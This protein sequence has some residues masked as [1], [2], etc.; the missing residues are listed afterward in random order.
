MQSMLQL[1]THVEFVSS[2]SGAMNNIEENIESLLLV[3]AFEL[4]RLVDGHLV[5]LV[6]MQQE[7]R[8]IARI[9]V[10]DGTGQPYQFRSVLRP[11]A[12]K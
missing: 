2:M 1:I 6:S 3:Y 4:V 11:R 7:Q 8:W 5:V 9:H 12:K 10:K